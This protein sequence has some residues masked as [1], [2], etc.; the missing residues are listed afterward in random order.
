MPAPVLWRVALLARREGDPVWAVRFTAVVLAFVL[1]RRTGEI[2]ELQLQDVTL[3]ADAGARVQVCRFMGGEQRYFVQRLVLHIPPGPSPAPHDLPMELLMR[4]L[5]RLERERA[6]QSRLILS[7]VGLSRVPGLSDLSAWLH[8]AFECL[9]ISAPDGDLYSSS[10]SRSGGTT[11][12]DVCGASG[13]AVARLLGHAG[14]DPRTVHA[15]YVD[16]VAVPS[17]EAFWL[18]GR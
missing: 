10:S 2:L 4:Q 8:E 13:P 15:H 16:P 7:T 5:T 11:A 6:P 3:T 1:V 18:C 12:A 14:D 17:L 9:Y